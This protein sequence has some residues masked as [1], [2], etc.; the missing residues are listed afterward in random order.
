MARL[1][2]PR[3]RVTPT[4]F[5]I[6]PDLLGVRLATPAR[7]AAALGI[8]LLLAGLVTALGGPGAAALA[9]AILFF[10]VAM[11]RGSRHPFRRAVRGALV[12]VGALILFGIAYGLIDSGGDSLETYG[13][14][15]SDESYAYGPQDLDDVPGMAGLDRGLTEAG[16]DVEL[17]DA[18]G[19]AASDTLSAEERTAAERD[20]RAL[21]D[22]L[23]AGDTL[24][25]DSLRETVTPV[26]AGAEVARLHARNA[27]LDDRADDLDDEVDDL[28]E[29]IESPSFM[30]SVRAFG[31]DFGL[32]LGWIGV[33]FTLTLAW[34]GGYTPGK[35]LLGIRV[36]R[37]DGRPLSLWNAFERF[38]GYAAA[39]VTGLVGFA[40]VLWD[41]NR[42]GVE[43]KI[44]GTVVIRMADPMTPL[45]VET[46]SDPPL[47]TGSDA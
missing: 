41:P 5:R 6:A 19:N 46:P 45:R 13:G 28:R 47:G 10:L 44:A 24:A 22:A 32:S 25:V 39:I 17:S 3:D 16:I 14:P 37:L 31:A 33:Y 4:A 18:L 23:A 11:R 12:G 27:A 43:D 1:D 30:R 35:R 15:G 2:D 21:A 36:V 7:R 42:Q 40:Q 34:W 8:D 20:L 9:A 38:G 26:V 29:A